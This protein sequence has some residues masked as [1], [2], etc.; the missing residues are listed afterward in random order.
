MAQIK[1]HRNFGDFVKFNH[2]FIDTNPLLY[3]HLEHTIDRVIKGKGHSPILYKFFNIVCQDCFLST[4]LIENE[5]LIYADQITEDMVDLL[6]SELEFSLFR[7]FQFFGTKQ[8]MDALFEKHRVEYDEQK[9]RNIYECFKVAENFQSSEG[10]MSMG[11]T[12][13]VNQLAAFTEQFNKEYYG[14]SAPP[15]NSI[16]IVSKSIL[17]DS[18]YQW[19]LN[20]QI[21]AL[22]QAM[23]DQF[24]FPVIGNVFTPNQHRGKNFASSIVHA[25][26]KGLLRVGNEKCM[27]VADAYNPA[28]NKAFVKAGYELCGEYVVRYKN[29]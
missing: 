4:L 3:Y 24:D 11:D 13:R 2:D 12:R 5:C 22:A 14:P 10:E 7:R 20:N 8:I 26:T 6:S 1:R 17:S 9:Y 27:L 21:C 18:L 16:E 23:H 15:I 25:L 29:K 19:N 28:S